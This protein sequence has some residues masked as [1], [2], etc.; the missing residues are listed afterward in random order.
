MTEGFFF[1]LQY[2]LSDIINLAPSLSNTSREETRQQQWDKEFMSDIK[3][4]EKSSINKLLDNLV[5]RKEKKKGKSEVSWHGSVKFPV[6]T[7]LK[8]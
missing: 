6:C 3:E 8:S 5:K 7:V 4:N 2:H 1:F